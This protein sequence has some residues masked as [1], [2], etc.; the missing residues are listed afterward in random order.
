MQDIKLR[1]VNNIGSL[2]FFDNIVD[3]IGKYSKQINLQNNANGIY[4]LEI[5]TNDGMI[6][7]K[8]I[9]Q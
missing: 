2:V 9:L 5:E 4:F 3:H 8:I 1:I 7:K 6:N